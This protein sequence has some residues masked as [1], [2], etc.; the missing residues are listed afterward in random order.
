METGTAIH[1]KEHAHPEIFS[2]TL[3]IGKWKK[4]FRP[5]Y[6]KTL[7]AEALNATVHKAEFRNAIA[8]YLIS[9]RR[10]CLVLKMDHRRIRKML[11]LFYSNVR[12]EIRRH[13]ETANKGDVKIFLKEAQVKPEDLF[14]DLFTEHELKNDRLIK[15]IT[16]RKVELPYYDP[17]LQRLKNDI[18]NYPFCSAIDYRGGKSPVLVK[19]VK[20]EDW[21]KMEELRKNKPQ[22]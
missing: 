16:G 17:Q 11:E 7:L 9:D 1:K 12:D 21:E 14:E 4:L 6:Y 5:V 22:L 18:H 15:L 19:L 2:F 20:K 13:L 10:L 3:Q 8:G